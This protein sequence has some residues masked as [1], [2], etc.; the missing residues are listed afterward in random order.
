MLTIGQL[1]AYAG[2]TVRAVRHYHRIGLL[3]EPARDSSGYRAYD[4]GDVVLLIRIRTLAE[5]GVPL[6]RVQELLGAT[7]AEFAEAVEQIDTRL[8]A[9]VRELQEHRR[10]IARLAAGDSLAVP[11]EVVPYLDKMRAS[12]VSEALVDG[13]RDG[14]IL[15]SARWPEKIPALMIDKMAQLDDPRTMQIY[16][17]IGELVDLGLNEDRLNAVADLLAEM[18]EDSAA[19]GQLN[20]HNEDMSDDAFVALLD[21]FAADAH[22][23]VERLQALMVERGWSGWSRIQRVDELS[24]TRRSPP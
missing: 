22:P 6:A 21:S 11:A 13:E 2:V 5:A 17:L 19:S 18:A 24:V 20:R 15:V 1:A 3:P 4:A 7:S 14:W 23:L 9:Q 8:R 12:G 16:R 10:R